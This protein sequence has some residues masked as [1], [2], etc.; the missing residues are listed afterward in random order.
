VE[1]Y[2]ITAS[3]RLLSLL[4]FLPG[5]SMNLL[6]LLFLFLSRFGIYFPPQKFLLAQ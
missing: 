3:P 4:I 2:V 6:P 1:E 5:G